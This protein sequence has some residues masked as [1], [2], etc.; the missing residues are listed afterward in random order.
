MAKQ[1]VLLA[2]RCTNTTQNIVRS[3]M[4]EKEVRNG[5][6]LEIFERGEADLHIPSHLHR[7]SIILSH[8]EVSQGVL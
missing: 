7:K 1:I 6:I 3:H 4:M 8:H 5:V 2:Q